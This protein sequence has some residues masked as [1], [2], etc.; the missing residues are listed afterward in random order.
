MKRVRKWLSEIFNPEEDLDMAA[1]GLA[2]NDPAVRTFWLGAMLNE[3]RQMNREVDRRLLAGV[4]VGLTDLC[5]RR[6]AYQDVLESLLSARRA[7]EKPKEERHNPMSQFLSSLDKV[8][9]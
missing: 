2:L 6:K 8:T 3:I 9:S 1:M 5:A 4:N 7:I